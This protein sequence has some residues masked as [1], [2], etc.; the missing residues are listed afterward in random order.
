MTLPMPAISSRTRSNRSPSVV[1]LCI[2]ME[3]EYDRL[4]LEWGMGIGQARIGMEWGYDRLGLGNG[5]RT[6]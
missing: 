1:S 4:G 6:G 5:N 3:W 2:G